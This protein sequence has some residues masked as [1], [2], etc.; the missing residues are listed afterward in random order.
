M[1]GEF[2]DRNMA[3]EFSLLEAYKI[4]SEKQGDNIDT[5]QWGEEHKITWK[6]NL[7]RDPELQSIFDLNPIA[8]SGDRNTIWNVGTPLGAT[9][10]HGVSYRQIFDL[11]DLNAALVV[12]PPGNS[13]QPGSPHYADHVEN[14]ANMKYNPLFVNWDDIQSNKK[15][16]LRLT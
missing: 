10:M 15:T 9:G 16:E 13:G 14:W 1:L 11:E 12:I 5:W 4:L 7:G 3:I 2:D 6:H 8:M